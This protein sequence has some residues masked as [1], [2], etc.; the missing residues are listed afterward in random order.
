[1]EILA[2]EQQKLLV[3]LYGSAVEEAAVFFHF[4]GAFTAITVPL[5]VGN[6]T[7]RLDSADEQW[8]GPGCITAA[9]LISGGD[10]S[11][12]L[13]PFSVVLFTRDREDRDDG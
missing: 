13:A 5:S 11:V 1:M 2:Y 10:V 12:S 3:V 8:N 9:T 4:G 6:W 7:R